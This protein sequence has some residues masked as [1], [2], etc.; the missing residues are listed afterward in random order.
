MPIE[1]VFE[2]M[3]RDAPRAIDSQCL[4]ALM[5]HHARSPANGSDLQAL[6]AS[7]EGAGRQV[8]PEEKHEAVAHI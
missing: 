7:V 5:T 1:K 6:S 3:Q 8:S 2:I 4:D